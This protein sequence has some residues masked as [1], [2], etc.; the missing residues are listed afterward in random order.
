MRDE[1]PSEPVNVE[2]PSNT[3]K[4]KSEPFRHLMVRETLNGCSL[5]NEVEAKQRAEHQIAAL[6]GMKPK[7]EL[8]GLVA[9]QIL[10]ANSAACECFRLAAIPE[11][12]PEY[13]E[14]N[15]KLAVKAQGSMVKLIESLQKLQ[16]KAGQQSVHVHHHH[17]QEDN[18]TQV[19][20]GNA[21]VNINH[22]QGE[23]ETKNAGQPLEP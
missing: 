11:Q 18:R 14:M 2:V 3:A 7:D 16:G 15:I 23:G 4:P 13:R 21:V 20:A 6:F 22:P 9:S 8:E 17:H 5:P 10:L 19:A 1:E 12:H